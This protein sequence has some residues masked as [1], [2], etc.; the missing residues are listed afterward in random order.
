M[1]PQSDFDRHAGLQCNEPCPIQPVTHRIER[2]TDL[3]FVT[4]QSDQPWRAL[5]QK[6]TRPSGQIAVR[7]YHYPL[8]HPP[9]EIWNL[10]RKK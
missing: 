2:G 4:S 10:A 3:D 1:A 7:Q 6:P 9:T 8:L 5:L